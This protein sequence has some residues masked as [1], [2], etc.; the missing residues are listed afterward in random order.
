MSIDSVSDGDIADLLAGL[1]R[2]SVEG[3]EKRSE[4]LRI[5]V[6]LGIPQEEAIKMDLRLFLDGYLVGR[7][8]N[9]RYRQNI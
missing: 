6:S 5:V 4:L 9:L 1:R 3:R 7:G 8:A 2:L